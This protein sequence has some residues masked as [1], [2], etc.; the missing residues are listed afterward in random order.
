ME[1]GVAVSTLKKVR[2][3]RIVGVVAVVS[4]AWSSPRP[5]IETQRW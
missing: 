5:P 1:Q 4:T 2:A 3:R